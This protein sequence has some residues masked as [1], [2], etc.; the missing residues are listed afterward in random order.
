M[1]PLIEWMLRTS[2]EFDLC[3]FVLPPRLNCYI[4]TINC[5]CGGVG[6]ARF[7]NDFRRNLRM[8]TTRGQERCCSALFIG[9]TTLCKTQRLSGATQLT[10]LDARD[11]WSE[12]L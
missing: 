8:R 10:D 1:A 9:A 7:E 11:K 6:A 3:L 2:A 4:P 12:R 5:L